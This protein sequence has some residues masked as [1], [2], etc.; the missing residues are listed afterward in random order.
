MKKQYFS[1][2]LIVLFILFPLFVYC[3]DSTFRYI[4]SAQW[5]FVEDFDYSGNLGAGTFQN[6]I[7]FYDISSITSPLETSKYYTRSRCYGVEV[8]NK[9]TYFTS[10]AHLYKCN[11]SDLSKP[12]IV[13][14]VS[15]YGGRDVIISNDSLW[16]LTV[17]NLFLLDTNL[18]FIDS[19]PLGNNAG[20]MITKYDNYIF[21]ANQTSGFKIFT[22]NTLNI[23][24]ATMPSDLGS[25][26]AC[27]SIVDNNILI[28]ADGR[29]L[30]KWDITN[31]FLPYNTDSVVFA[32]TTR[33]CVL[34]STRDTVYAAVAS[35]AI[36]NTDDGVIAIDVASMTKLGEQPGYFHEL[37]RGCY[38]NGHFIIGSFAH[39]SCGFQ[40]VNVKSPAAIQRVGQMDGSDYV[41]GVFIKG[42]TV[43]TAAGSYG[44][45]V[46]KKT[47]NN[48]TQLGNIRK[49]T[50][51]NVWGD[52][53]HVYFGKIDGDMLY[54]ARLSDY[55]IIDSIAFNDAYCLTGRD[56]ILYVAGTNSFR[57]INITNPY[58]LRQMDVYSIPGNG[59]TLTLKDNEA[60]VANGNA[61]YRFDVSDPS[62]IFLINTKYVNN[63]RYVT[64][65]DS[66]LYCGRHQEKIMKYSLPL[67]LAIDSVNEPNLYAVTAGDGFVFASCYRNGIKGFDT[68]FN[69]I[70]TYVTPG[71]AFQ[72]KYDSGNV[73]LADRSSLIRF[74]FNNK[75]QVINT[76]LLRE[77][78]NTNSG[79]ILFYPNPTNGII[80]IKTDNTEEIKSI[81]LYTVLGEKAAEFTFSEHINVASL[82]HGIYLAKVIGTTNQ[83]VRTEKI[84]KNFW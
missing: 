75:Q 37:Y 21:L 67:M 79:E 28:A 62:N 44:I 26:V 73:Y 60:F 8:V 16:Y 10:D 9:T 70:D 19:I 15:R 3:Q 40:V 14:S 42:D 29:K 49:E 84:I 22:A 50:V 65:S 31:K 12:Y 32:N 82:P 39:N 25:S 7:K 74:N 45:T 69:L 30:T 24:S 35:N 72:A 13:D 48:F 23:I 77:K 63:A 33:W 52:N 17:N 83:V 68:N 27:L 57:T 20:K 46:F 36:L 53:R 76:G 51:W 71:W 5:T 18:V 38:K 64:V 58:N 2:Y 61:I 1:K 41:R 80:N 59:Y 54:C 78:T 56:T 4:N 43:Y 34:N 55:V 81:V 11:I 47:G 66:F 6:G